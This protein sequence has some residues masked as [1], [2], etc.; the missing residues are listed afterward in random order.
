MSELNE[1]I[2]APYEYNSTELELIELYRRTEQFVQNTIDSN[3]IYDRTEIRNNVLVYLASLR[4]KELYLLARH[5]ATVNR[6][7]KKEIYVEFLM[8]EYV[9]QILHGKYKLYI[10]SQL[11]PLI[12]EDLEKMYQN[13]LDQLIWEDVNVNEILPWIQYA[14]D[15]QLYDR[16]TCAMLSI[17]NIRI[18]QQCHEYYMNGVYT[19]IFIGNNTEESRYENFICNIVN[20]PNEPY[21][22]NI[23]M[24][25]YETSTNRVYM[26]VCTHSFCVNCVKNQIKYSTLPVGILVCSYCRKHTKQLGFCNETIMHEFTE[27]E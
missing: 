4:H 27:N 24:E 21:T 15:N 5:I 11:D 1:E 19:L 16:A 22:C 3:D 7:E 10:H 14:I 9:K 18:T 13:V 12:D 2:T 20:V 6:N 25:D 8:L 23:C 17:I 26:T